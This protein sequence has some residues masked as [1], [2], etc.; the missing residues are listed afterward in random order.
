MQT[1]TKLIALGA[2]GAVGAA[3]FGVRH[4]LRKRKGESNID[5]RFD[6]SDVFDE[7]LDNDEPIVVAEEVVVITEA[8]PYEVDL[9]LIPANDEMRNR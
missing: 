4:M 1:K 2:A 8:G 9:E 7:E 5:W 3:A 6:T